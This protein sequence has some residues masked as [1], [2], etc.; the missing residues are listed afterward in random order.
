MA[1]EMLDRDN[2]TV[3]VNDDVAI[4]NSTCTTG[5]R[6]VAGTLVVDEVAAELTGAI[7]KAVRHHAVP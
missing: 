4:E 6:G 5:R 1:A 7:L 3:I 2:A